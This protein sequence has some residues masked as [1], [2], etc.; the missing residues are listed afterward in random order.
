MQT[1]HGIS[2]DVLNANT[3]G[4]IPLNCL[5]EGGVTLVRVPHG[6]IKVRL[7]TPHQSDVTVTLDDKTLLVTQIPAGLTELAMGKDG[8]AMTFAPATAGG[9]SPA[10]EPEVIVTEG[11]DSEVAPEVLAGIVTSA[12]VKDGAE[13]EQVEE[14]SEPTQPP[15]VSGF[16]VV[17]VKFTEQA[18][19]PG[20]VPPPYDVQ[21]VAFQM[22]TPEDHALAIAA[23]FHKIVPPEKIEK[24]WCSHCRRMEDR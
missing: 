17:Q 14:K 22:N 23:N 10:A 2:I 5:L 21:E 9:E 24:R 1:K 16:L 7:I 11:F 18:P 4:R 3:P 13:G 12:I 8:R 19:I 20:I 6:P 15:H